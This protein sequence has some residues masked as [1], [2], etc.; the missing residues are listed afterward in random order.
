METGSNVFAA[1][2]GGPTESASNLYH[3]RRQTVVLQQ[4]SLNADNFL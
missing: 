1:L 4:H 3:S 2:V